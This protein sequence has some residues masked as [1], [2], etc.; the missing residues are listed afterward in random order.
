MKKVILL[1][2][3]FMPCIAHAQ[4]FEIKDGAV[5]MTKI[6]NTELSIEEV[7]DVAETFFANTYGDS[8]RTQ[9]V[10]TPTHLIYSGLFMNVASHVGGLWVLDYKHTIDIA[11]KDGRVR[12]QVSCDKAIYRGTQSIQ[13]YEID[14]ASSY[15]VAQNAKCAVGSKKL[16]ENALENGCNRM[17]EVI[18]SFENALKNKVTEEDW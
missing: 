1:L 8:N 9:R 6:I 13:S 17:R 5:V 2:L 7:H 3:L 14:I 16:M 10:N 4:G 15:P 18:S 12:I 11:I